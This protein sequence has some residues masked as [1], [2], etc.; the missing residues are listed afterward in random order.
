MTKKSELLDVIESLVEA[1]AWASGSG[2][3]APG[4]KAHTGWVKLGYPALLKGYGAMGQNDRLPR[5][6]E[7]VEVT[8]L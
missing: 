7:E 4:G 5:L 8:G 6:S 2:D 1:L 3:F